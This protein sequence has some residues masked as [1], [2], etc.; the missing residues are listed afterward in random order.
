M[1]FIGDK[2]EI[3]GLLMLLIGSR[4]TAFHFTEHRPQ[5]DWDI[6]CSYQEFVVWLAANLH[7]VKRKRLRDDNSKV[8]II[9]QQDTYFEFEFAR[10]NH[11]A[12][13][14]LQLETGVT[15]DLP[16]GL[17]AVVASPEALF[18]T[19]KSHVHLPIKWPK[20]IEDYH[21]LKN[22]IGDTSYLEAYLKLRKTEMSKVF[23]ER[24]INLNMKNEDFFMKSNKSVKRYYEH[25]DLHAATCYYGEPLYDQL[26]IDKTKALIDRALFDKLSFQDKLRTVREECYAIALE[27]R[28]IP[29]IE[30]G[31]AY[32]SQ[33]AF[34]YALE[35]I[36]TT[37]T[38]GWFREFAIENYPEIKVLDKDYV[39]A[40]KHAV[41]TGRIQKQ[42]QSHDAK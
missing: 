12:D 3:R 34:M 24:T 33:G 11:S 9:D 5:K 17:H 21:F 8:I 38:K 23:Q 26:K 42:E 30:A 1:H 27:R 16:N 39:T 2:L 7:C 22:R 10:P 14:L 20:N 36:S 41:S 15:I 4:A 29:A 19:K 25:D 37:L 32:D 40:F 18:M 28:I 6:I 35:R 31:E 13:M